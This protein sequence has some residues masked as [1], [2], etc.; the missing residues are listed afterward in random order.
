MDTIAKVKRFVKSECQKPTSKYGYEP[1]PYHFIPVVKYSLELADKLRGDREVVEIAAWLHD[2]GSI[3]HGRAN[4]HI[5][6]AKIATN[7]LQKL[8]YPPEKIE[9]VRRC[10]IHHRGSQRL[11]NETIEEQILADADA[12]SAYDNLP[13]IFKAAFVYEGLDQGEAKKSV[14]QKL[15]N[16]WRQLNFPDSKK[17]VRPKYLA[18]MLLLK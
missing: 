16:K 18:A 5:T 13:G 11:K 4:H 10:I 8:Q 9:L 7:L 17:L 2:I 12:M 3:I 15:A 1:Y 6:G 14:R